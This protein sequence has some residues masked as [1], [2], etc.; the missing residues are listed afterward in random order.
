MQLVNI[1][2]SNQADRL[3][4][5]VVDDSN[6]NRQLLA[7]M[8]NKMGYRPIL[9]VDGRDALAQCELCLP[10]LVLMDVAMP[11]MSGFDV[12]RLMRRRFDLWVPIIFLSANTTNQDVVE[13]LRA[14]GDDYLFKPVNYEILQAK[15]QIF[16][17]R[18]EQNQRLLDY[19]ERIE[20]ETDTAREFIKQLTALD[21]INDPLVRFFLKPAENFSGDLIAV[22]RMPDDCLHVLLADSAGHGLTAALAVIPITQPFYQ[23]TAK[24]FDVPAIIREINRRVREYLP[25]PRFVAASLMSF[26][27]KTGIIQVWN[28][29]CPPVLLLSDDGEDVI[30]RFT[31]RHLPLGVVGDGEFDAGLE[32]YKL[33]DQ[34]GHLLLCSDGA[35]ELR[36]GDNLALEHSGLLAGAKSSYEDNLFDRIIDVIEDELDDLPPADDIAMIMVACALPVKEVRQESKSVAWQSEVEGCGLGGFGKPVWEFSLTLT[37]QQLKRLDV[38]PFLLNITGQIEGGRADGKLFLVLS[39][40]FNNALDHGVLKLD[41]RL[42]NQPEGME[43][44]FE[45]RAARLAELELGQIVM[46]LEKMGCAPCACMKISMTDSGDGFEFADHRISDVDHNE[47]RHGRGIAL[48]DTICKSL[49]YYAHGAEVVAYVEIA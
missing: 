16:Q 30:H 13:G 24:G 32:Y 33:T 20:D 8:L 3:K 41:S 21:K 14:G 49:Q 47:Q 27:P 26:N 44:Y 28:G 42:K 46:H 22:A 12:V 15:I 10:D 11:E 45:T 18:L 5:L 29:G 43:L 23:M 17:D 34:P 31:S 7:A 4:V 2:A 39:E 9:A 38:V 19:R 48:L 25:L 1:S 6:T 37:A 35:T 40:L 36:M